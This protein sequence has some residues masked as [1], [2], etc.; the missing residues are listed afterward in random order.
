MVDR[1]NAKEAGREQRQADYG[2][3]RAKHYSGSNLT[4]VPYAT[5]SLMLVPISEES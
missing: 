5:I 1:C 3:Q 4:A 2:D